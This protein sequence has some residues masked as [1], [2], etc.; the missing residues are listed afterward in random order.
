MLFHA[1]P[2]WLII[3]SNLHRRQRMDSVPRQSSLLRRIHMKEYFHWF[4]SSI[5][6]KERCTSKAT[7]QSNNMLNDFVLGIFY[8]D[9]RDN[10]T[11]IVFPDWKNCNGFHEAITV[12]S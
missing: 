10:S 5:S 9:K 6:I 11:W 12:T 8:H 1:V 7:L 2:K 4:A 3:Y